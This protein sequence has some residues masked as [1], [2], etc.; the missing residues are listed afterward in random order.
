MAHIETTLFYLNLLPMYLSLKR[1]H[2][3]RSYKGTFL[4]ITFHL[5]A[6]YMTHLFHLHW[7]SYIN[8]MK[9]FNNKPHYIISHVLLLT[10]SIGQIIS[11]QLSA[12]SPSYSFNVRGHILHPYKMKG[13]SDIWWMKHS[14]ASTCSESQNKGFFSYNCSKSI[15]QSNICFTG[16]HSYRGRQFWI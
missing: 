4:Y 9:S 1:S 12:H 2:P 7:S 14:T 11:W 5:H 16:T 10:P 6:H 8:I 15:P 3:L 13:T